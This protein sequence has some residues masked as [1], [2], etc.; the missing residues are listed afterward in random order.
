MYIS[1]TLLN[2]VLPSGNRAVYEVQP[3]H[4]PREGIAQ[5]LEWPRMYGRQI[6]VYADGKWYQPGGSWEPI[7]D[8][9][10]VSALDSIEK[11]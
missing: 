1:N 7:T 6:A 5:S 11:I 3:Q 2:V 4:V 8:A 10:K 9:E